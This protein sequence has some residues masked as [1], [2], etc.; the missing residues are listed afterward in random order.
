MPRFHWTGRTADGKTVEGQTDA[1]S[2]EEVIS[3]LRSQRIQVTKLSSTDGEE[4]LD[5]SLAAP[6]PADPRFSYRKAAPASL[7]DRMAR[8]R[9]TQQPHRFRALLIALTFL[10]A[11]FGIGYAAPA[12]IWRCDRSDG[13]TVSCSLTERALGIWTIREQKLARVTACD[14]ETKWI[15]GRDKRGVPMQR[16]SMRLVLRDRNGASI[17][18]SHWDQDGGVGTSTSAVQSAILNLIRGGITGPVSL[19]QADG[20]IHAIASGL[21]LLG[22][23]M[24]ALTLVSLFKRPTDAIYSAV[25]RLAA[26]A[27][28]RRQ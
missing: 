7:V 18:P 28:A 14:Y 15:P 4:A 22:L 16:A 17:S 21:A 6:A 19:W 24:L 8:E 12:T 23:L 20:S 1:D 10:A 26:D 2:K 5:P 9:A 27:D 25:E 13:E 11:A 3:R